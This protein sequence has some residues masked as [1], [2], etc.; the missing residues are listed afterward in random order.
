MTEQKHTAPFTQLE[1][2]S[3]WTA[4]GRAVIYASATAM[5][6]RAGEDHYEC[7]KA[8]ADLR[9]SVDPIVL[10]RLNSHEALVAALDRIF[11]YVS[12]VNIHGVGEQPPPREDGQ[13]QPMRV[14]PEEFAR[15]FQE[16]GRLASAAL[17]QAGGEQ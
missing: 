12:Y 5:C 2:G 7:R 17:Q 14:P 10:A 4:D 1:N 11:S 9:L 15:I 6:G 3:V 16:I 13:P 8:K